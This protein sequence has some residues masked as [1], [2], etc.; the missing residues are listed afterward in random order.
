M[1]SDRGYIS[2]DGVEMVFSTQDIDQL[3]GLSDADRAVLRMLGR[4]DSSDFRIFAMA[5]HVPTGLCC[6]IEALV[7]IADQRIEVKQ[8]KVNP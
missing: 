7:H 1:D 2:L 6:R 3:Q 8:W 5:R 4:F